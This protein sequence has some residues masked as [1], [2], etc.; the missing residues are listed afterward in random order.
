MW[1]SLASAFLAGLCAGPVCVLHCGALHLGY[2]GRHAAAPSR[3]LAGLGALWLAGRLLAYLAVGLAIGL[4]TASS[5]PLPAPWCLSL[6]AG[7]VLLVS[8]AVPAGRGDGCA[9]RGGPL[10]AAGGA[11]TMGLLSG[12][13]PC[14]PLL[15]AGFLAGASRGPAAAMLTLGAFF[16]GSSLVLLPTVFG[17]SLLPSSWRRG[18]RLPGRCLTVL[19]AVVVLS[20]GVRQLRAAAADPVA[21]GVDTP[22]AVS[23]APDAVADPPPAAAGTR[24]LFAKERLR[25]LLSL[26][27]VRDLGLSLQEARYYRTMPDGRVQCRLCPRGCVLAEG[28]RGVCRVRA[29]VDGRLRALTY[30]LPVAL[31]ADPIE[32]KPLYHMLPGSTALSVATV[33][34]N[35][36][37]VFCQNYEI[38]Q[39]S[40]EDV[41]RRH[42]PPQAVVAAAVQRG[43]AG[44]AYTYTEPTV[45]FEYMLETARLAKAEGLRNYWITCG[46]IQEE[47]LRELCQVLDGANV[48]LKGFS[49]D[50]YVTYCDQRLAPVLRTLRILRRE[51]VHVEVTNLVIPGANDDPDM[52][53]AMC[54]W[55]RQELGRETPLHL[56]AFHPA[57]KLTRTPPTPVSTLVRLRDVAR[58][59]GLKHVYIGNA[60]VEGAG[61]TACPACGRAVVRRSGYLVT[62]NRLEKG[63]CPSCQAALSGVW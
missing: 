35:S 37:C 9:C 2:L 22:P 47:P 58:E 21:A 61:D 10:V 1:S 34:C 20:T 33:G 4:V 18:L 6:A 32:K 5:L 43:D 41:P 38:S 53:R 8:A 16:A 19:A 27:R 29:H 49:D 50:F 55:I 52:V 24:P 40:P 36:G 54:R 45:F 44:I 12:L 17:L 56:S 3:R 62:S 14:P 28:E 15:A 46:Q 11:V 13:A 26:A 48:D 31:R 59:E 51:G 42:I 7:L 39:A 23:P 60:A 25:E 30:A 63:R 57:Y